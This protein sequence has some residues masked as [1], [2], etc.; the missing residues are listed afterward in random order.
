MQISLDDIFSDPSL[1]LFAFEGD[2]A[3]FARMDRASFAR[4]IFVDTRIVAV[5]PIFVRV[6]LQP[7]IN[8]AAAQ[9]ASPPRLGFIHHMAQMGSTLLARALDQPGRNLVIREPLHLRQ[10]GVA[11]G[12]GGEGARDP[13]WRAM[14]DFSLTMLGKRFDPATPTIVKGNVPISLIAG[15]V[16]AVDPGQPALVMHYPL[17]DYLAAVLRTPGH[18]DWVRR[19]ASEVSLSKAPWVGD[20]ADAGA[21]LQAAGLWLAMA[22]RFQ[23][24]V[25]VNPDAVSVDANLLFERPAETIV[26]ASRHFG[27]P[28]EQDQAL[29]LAQGPLFATYGKDPSRAYD[30]QLRL[31]R[32]AEAKQQLAAE[33]AQ[34]RAWVTERAA[35]LDLAA[36]LDR[37][38]LGEP[39]ALFQ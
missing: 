9:R 4:S 10:L 18:Q 22:L 33:I 16:A 2:H 30:P 27:T 34:A 29:G 36:S 11:A 19:V 14:L 12:A 26:A 8:R 35:D 23:R 24:L 13:S 37:P 32:R 3:R 31:A 1:M 5:D 25:E 21:V 28:I 38:L 15:E 20:L 17:E 6:P 7:L 39:V